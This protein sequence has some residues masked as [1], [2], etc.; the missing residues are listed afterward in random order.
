MAMVRHEE[1]GCRGRHQVPVT[2]PRMLSRL[3]HDGY[4]AATGL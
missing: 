3:R 2:D 4:A 1:D